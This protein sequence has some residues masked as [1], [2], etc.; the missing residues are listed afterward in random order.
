M[1]ETSRQNMNITLIKRPNNYISHDRLNF[2][3]SGPRMSSDTKQTRQVYDVSSKRQT[4]ARNSGKVLCS[5]VFCM[6]TGNALYTTTTITVHSVTREA[7]IGL[8]VIYTN[9]QIFV[10]N[11]HGLQ[12]PLIYQKNVFNNVLL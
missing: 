12:S 5:F 11:H 3:L 2:K 7:S 10:C 1:I 4:F 8:H 6:C 9:T